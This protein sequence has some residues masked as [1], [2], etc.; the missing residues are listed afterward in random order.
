M[1]NNIV[2]KTLSLLLAGVMMAS[3]A[4][5]AF[6]GE[7]SESEAGAASAA[8]ETEKTAQEF[9]EPITLAGLYSEETKEPEAQP[10]GEEKEDGGEREEADKTDD[11][12]KEHFIL[13]DSDPGASYSYDGSRADGEL[14][15]GEYTALVY[16]AGENV[17]F[18]VQTE[19]PYVIYTLENRLFMSSENIADGHI[20][21]TMPDTDLGLSFGTIEELGIMEE[22]ETETEL[23]QLPEEETQLESG[24]SEEIEENLTVLE[25]PKRQE[26]AAGEASEAAASLE[27]FQNDEEDLSPEDL[28]SVLGGPLPYEMEADT[29]IDAVS[30]DENAVTDQTVQSTE[31]IQPASDEERETD[32]AQEIP[33]ETQSSDPAVDENLP[34]AETEIKDI[35]TAD[36]TQETETEA[37]M[38]ADEAEGASLRIIDGYPVAGSEHSSSISLSLIL[39]S[40]YFI[41]LTCKLELYHSLTRAYIFI[42]TI[43]PHFT[44]LLFSVPSYWNPAFSNAL[45]EAILCANGSAKIRIISVF[46]N[47][48]SQTCLIAFVIYPFPQ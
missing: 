23:S 30:S 4:S 17:S 48:Y 10:Q 12:K 27:E 18:S 41:F 8:Q 13:L 39:G 32:D 24:V 1:K 43:L 9:K 40:L 26:A 37:A 33:E 34:E 16:E 7:V 38:N 47:T 20:S 31:D 45:H 42:S 2:R 15:T 14:S 11:R 22:D 35:S 3:S 6:A 21:F 28:H 44:A 25:E 46:S 19:L 29:S 5:P 36:N